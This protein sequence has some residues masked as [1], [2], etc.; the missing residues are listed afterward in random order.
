VSAAVG[1]APTGDVRLISLEDH[2]RFARIVREHTGIKLGENKRQLLSSRLQK[3]MRVHGLTTFAAYWDYLNEHLDTELGD[4]INAIT[5]NLTSF[6][7][8]NHH[9]EFLRR[10]LDEAP[11]GS[12]VRIWSAGCS[13]GEEPYS[14][15]M[16][17]HE[18]SAPSRR[19]HLKVAATDIDTQC[20]AVAE[21]GVY[22]A[23]STRAI[24]ETRMAAHFLRGKGSNEG[25]VRVR[26]HVRDLIHFQPL[27]LLDKWPFDDA[28]DLVFCR[29]V[30]IYFDDEV[31]RALFER[32]A[33]VLKPG[34][35]IVIGH[36][37]NLQRVCGRFRNLGQ[38]IYAKV[39]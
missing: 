2:A 3:R 1:A 22:G 39:K 19:V 7:R 34:G 25:K 14:I 11:S 29:N 35:H 24:G 13:T 10:Y 20:V 9:F 15:A 6:F 32:F 26:P 5:T 8:E 17:Y 16:V 12:T 27:N 4:F 38:T 23:E 28:F 37:E 36:S 18:S 21:R 30:V 33:G 31:Q